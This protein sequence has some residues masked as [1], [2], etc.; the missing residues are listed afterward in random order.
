MCSIVDYMYVQHSRGLFWN[1]KIFLSHSVPLVIISGMD[2]VLAGEELNLTCTVTSGTSSF[3]SIQWIRPSTAQITSN[4]TT[5]YS[6]M[7]TV[8]SIRTSDSGVYICMVIFRSQSVFIN[9]T[10]SVI[11]QSKNI[12]IQCIYQIILIDYKA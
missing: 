2:R 11:V 3:T 10:H 7:L 8:D 12:T 5:L 1:L 6:L 4:N 9:V